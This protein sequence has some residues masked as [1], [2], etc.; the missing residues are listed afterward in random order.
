MRDQMQKQISVSQLKE[1]QTMQNLYQQAKMYNDS[2]ILVTNSANPDPTMIHRF[3]TLYHQCDLQFEDCHNK[4]EHD[5]ASAN[6]SHGSNGKVEMHSSGGGMMNSCQCCANGGHDA[7]IHQKMD[8]LHS[9][10]AL[11][12]H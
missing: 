1:V 2:L 9:L 10:H 3:E 7:S 12:H 11:Y 8:D 4:F 5:Y 6:H